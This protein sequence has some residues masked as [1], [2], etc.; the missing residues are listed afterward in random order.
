M[1]LV[2]EIDRKCSKE[3]RILIEKHFVL[4]LSKKNSLPFVNKEK[5]V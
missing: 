4:N 5:K 3:L 2:L 1:Y